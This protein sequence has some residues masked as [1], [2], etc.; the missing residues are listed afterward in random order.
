M[1]VAASGGDRCR[2]WSGA[3]AHVRRSPGEAA[4]PARP[5]QAAGSA[6]SG[7]NAISAAPSSGAS[8]PSAAGTTRTSARG[9]RQRVADRARPRRRRG[10]SGWMRPNRPPST[11]SRGLRMFT[12]PASPMPSQRPTC[13]E[14]GERRLGA[15]LRPR[16]STASSRRDRASAGW[17]ASARSSALADL[18]LPAADRAAAARASGRVDRHVADLAGVA[19][20]A[21]QRAPV[22]DQAAA[23]ADLA[24]HVQH[25]VDA[26]GRAAAVPRRGRPGRRRWR[27]R[28]GRRSPSARASRS[29]SGTSTPAQVRGHRHHAVAAP[30]DARDRDADAD[31]AASRRASGRSATRAARSA[32]TSSTESSTLR[33]VDPDP[34]EDL[35]A[36]ADDARPRASRRRSRGQ[37]G[38]AVGVQADERRGP[39]GRAE[40]DGALLD[41][42]AGG[43]QLA[44]ERA[45]R[46]A[47]Q[48]GARR[49]ARSARAVPAR[50][51][52]G[53][54][55]S[56]SR[57]GRS[58][59]AAR[60]RRGR[61]ARFVFLSCK[62][63]P[64][65]YTGGPV[66]SRRLAAAVRGGRPEEVD[67]DAGRSPATRALGHPVDREHRDGEGHPGHAAGRARARSWRSR[68]A[69]AGRQQASPRASGS[70]A[71]TAPTRRCWPTPTSTPST[72]RCR[73][74][75]TPLDD[76]GRRGPASTSCAR[77]RWR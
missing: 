51:A 7:S 66:S 20:R 9:R 55:R 56:G 59:C 30:D 8:T 19:G 26:D 21:G 48:A 72:S 14:R 50:E 16:A 63:V 39:A 34:L 44:D 23:D 61:L 33:P 54:W 31:D 58:R 74:T 36:E 42:E 69:T 67:A 45:D 11:T 76:R 53:R 65:S 18:G 25:V 29:P 12:S 22:D 5:N 62:R 68:R 13:V 6:S 17:P 64:D 28:S 73:T 77:S 2:R 52:R 43:G 3:A 1:P 38:G 49:R 40:R 47:R 57:D 27:P 37:D 35:A 10:R 70:R 75:S 71:R 24:R 46:A 60:R 4:G 15:R 41:D 32:T